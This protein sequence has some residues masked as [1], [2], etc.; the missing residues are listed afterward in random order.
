[1]FFLHL[2]LQCLPLLVLSRQTY[3]TVPSTSY[4]FRL[5]CR[6][7]LI[8]LRSTLYLSC[9][10]ILSREACHTRRGVPFF[11][12]LSRE[13]GQQS[14]PAVAHSIE[15]RLL[16]NRSLPTLACRAIML[17]TENIP[18]IVPRAGP[19]R[20][21]RG[22]PHAVCQ[23]E[24]GK[25]AVSWEG[26]RKLRL[27]TSLVK[28]HRCRILCSCSCCWRALAHRSERHQKVHGMMITLECIVGFVSKQKEQQQ[29]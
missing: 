19:Q 7:K 11:V 28:L 1:M 18:K 4:L 27:D 20:R 17:Q 8:T 25:Q 13:R 6:E 24:D 10:F 16:T 15:V 2:P 14:V 23:E 12:I 29:H 9:W 5:F 21:A 3:H 22:S 26:L